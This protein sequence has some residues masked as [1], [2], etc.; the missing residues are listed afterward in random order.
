MI[1]VV[2]DAGEDDN[3][4]GGGIGGVNHAR[5]DDNHVA[6][7]PADKPAPETSHKKEKSVLQAKLTKLAIQVHYYHSSKKLKENTF[8][9][10]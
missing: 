8:I 4:H 9:T 1:K 3:N 5:V 2:C 7:P 10:N 6:A